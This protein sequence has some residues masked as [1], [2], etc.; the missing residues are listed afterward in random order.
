MSESIGESIIDDEPQFKVNSD[1]GRKGSNK[2]LLILTVLIVFCVLLV[3]FS[4]DIAVFFEE[5]N[6]ESFT[7]N[8]FN[9]L[10]NSEVLDVNNPSLTPDKEFIEGDDYLIINDG[11]ND[12]LGQDVS[13]TSDVIV[14]SSVIDKLED[15]NYKLDSLTNNIN[16]LAIAVNE[17]S[18]DKQIISNINDSV[19]NIYKILL[20]EE[21]DN[22]KR[23][24]FIRSA[25]NKFNTFSSDIKIQ[26][27]QF[28][29][30]ILHAET[31]ANE[32][33]LIGYKKSSPRYIEKL[34]VGDNVGMWFLSKIE[35]SNVIFT[36]K[37][38]ESKKVM[39]P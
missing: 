33:R 30:E 27:E 39:I 9:E 12:S 14:D 18:I 21:K 37:D 8:E 11:T 2:V 36:S 29:F 38:G 34:Y 35:D 13:F 17:S 20:S 5:K 31:W 1:G 10:P 16:L 22:L 4:D 28:D 19:D 23:H 3:S 6:I 7:N 26:S 24:E 32:K 15:I 25:F